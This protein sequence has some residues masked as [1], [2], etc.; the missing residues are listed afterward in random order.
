M[1]RW[2]DNPFKISATSEPVQ[3]LGRPITDSDPSEDPTQRIRSMVE[4]SEIFLLI[5]GTPQQP[6]CGFSANTVAIIESLG[7]PYQTF[8]VL[9][10]E[11]I[12]T[13]AKDFS[14]WPTFP[15]VYLKGEFIG[16]NDILTEM[17]DAGELQ[18]MAAGSGA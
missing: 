4:S 10:D 1:H 3:A 2:D 5:K 11:S 18:Q 15:Q 16:G 14:A 12:R 6:Q 8:D 7:V 9:S 17:Y 13:A